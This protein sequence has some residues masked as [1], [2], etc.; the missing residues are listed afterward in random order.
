MLKGY[1]YIG[2]CTTRQGGSA[3]TYGLGS[4]LG[5]FFDHF[6]FGISDFWTPKFGTICAVYALRLIATNEILYVGSTGRLA[7]RLFA[8]YLGGLGGDTTRRIHL[9]LF[10]EGYISTVELGYIDAVGHVAKEVEFKQ[11]YKN[12]HHGNL[13]PWNRI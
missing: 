5:C 1:N 11:R 8:N 3:S 12:T 9:K 13:P 2:H 4:S 7:R 6:S 10:D